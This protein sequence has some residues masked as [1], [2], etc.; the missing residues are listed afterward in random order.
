IIAP[1]I[2]IVIAVVDAGAVYAG[3][4]THQLIKI[5]LTAVEAAEIVDHGHG[6]LHG[7]MGLEKK[8]LVAFHGIAGR[9]GFAEA[10]VGEALDLAPYLLH[11]RNRICVLC[12]A[13]EE[14]LL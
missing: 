6:E 11:Y 7:K 9:M 1:D 12:A 14:L 10:V 5:E 3:A 13:G 4:R 8:A 2:G